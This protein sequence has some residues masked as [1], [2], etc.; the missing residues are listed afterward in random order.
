M[1]YFLKEKTKMQGGPHARCRRGASIEPVTRG[2]VVYFGERRE[3]GSEGGRAEGKEG[4]GD[5][6]RWRGNGDKYPKTGVGSMR[7]SL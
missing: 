5:K 7:L 3:G 4:E 6:M 1:D 2:H